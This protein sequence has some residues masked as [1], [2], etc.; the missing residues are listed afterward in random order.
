MKRLERLHFTYDAAHGED[1]QA[2]HATVPAVCFR[3]KTSDDYNLEKDS[4]HMYGDSFL[5]ES[6]CMKFA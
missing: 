3:E 2:W 1:L 4:A 6:C 5:T